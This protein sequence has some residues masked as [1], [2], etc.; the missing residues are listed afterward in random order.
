MKNNQGSRVVIATQAQ[1]TQ[2]SGN[3]KPARGGFFY[4]QQVLSAQT[5]VFIAVV[6]VADNAR[7]LQRGNVTRCWAFGA[8]FNGEGNL[9]TFIKSFVV[10][11]LDSREMDEYVLAA[12]VRSDK[13]KTFIRVKPFY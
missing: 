6:S 12:I 4:Y 10:V 8:I 1:A 2:N 7:G 11:A 9:L 5:I 3:K 13:A